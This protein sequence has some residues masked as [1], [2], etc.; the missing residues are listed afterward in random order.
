[1][2]FVLFFD[3][4]LLVLE[5]LCSIKLFFPMHTLNTENPDQL[6]YNNTLLQLTVLGGVRLDSL[7]RMRVTLKVEIPESPRPPLRHNLDLYNDIQTE[8]F[9]RKIAERLEV[10]TSVASASLSELT[11]KLEHYRVE[12]IKKSKVDTFKPKVLSEA[13][14]AEEETFFKNPKIK[15]KK[16]I[17]KDKK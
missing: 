15:G 2:Q 10:G 1:M 14:I 7:D 8:K 4:I 3:T 16:T 9:I 13:E 11:E 12:E 5:L 17:K 6:I